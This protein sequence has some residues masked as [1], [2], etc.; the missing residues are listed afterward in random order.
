M[1]ILTE[2]ILSFRRTIEIYT[3]RHSFNNIR[4]ANDSAMMANID[5]KICMYL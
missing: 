5:I 2:V 1:K 4:Y 3:D